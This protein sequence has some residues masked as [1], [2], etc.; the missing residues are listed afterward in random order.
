MGIINVNPSSK[1]NK[2]REQRVRRFSLLVDDILQ[3]KET[4]SILDVG[5]TETF[6]HVWQ[7]KF[8]WDRIKVTCVNIDTSDTVEDGPIKVQYGDAR[9]LE[10]FADNSFDICF[11][12][13]VIEHVGGWRDMTAMANAVRRVAPAYFIQKPNFWFPIEPH[14]RTP[15]LHWLPEQLRYRIVSRFKC[16]FWAKGNSINEAML[17]IESA[18]LVDH[19]QFSWL[20]PDAKIERERYFGFTKS[21]IAIRN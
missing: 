7:D 6:W 11:S 21:L 5:G 16:G 4:C 9:T 18:K 20:F 15:L 8:Q 2:F 12:N 17:T 13:S 10:S 14:A 19:G 3:K 1:G